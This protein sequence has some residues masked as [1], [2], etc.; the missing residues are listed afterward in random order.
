[1]KPEISPA[2]SFNTQTGHPSEAGAVHRWPTSET[3]EFSVPL[4]AP[5][6]GVKVWAVGVPIKSSRQSMLFVEV[7]LDCSEAVDG[8][9]TTGYKTTFVVEWSGWNTMYFTASSLV[10]IGAPAGLHQVKRLRLVAGTSTLE[11]TVLE[12]GVVTWTSDVPLMWDRSDWMHTGKGTLPSR[13]EGLDV[14]W[15]YANLRYLQKPGRRHQTAYT[16]KMDLDISGYQA[17]TVW[18]ATDIRA[19]FSLVL[20]IDGVAVRTI[21]R[22]RGLGGGDEMRALISGHRLT[23]LTIEL[24][25]AEDAV[26][27]EIE[28]QVASSLRWV[29][30]ERKGV[31]TAK[32]GQVHG[33]TTVLPPIRVE[34]LESNI[35]P[36]GIM[37]SREDFLKL[38]SAAQSPGPLKKMADEIIAEATAHLDYSPEQYAGRYLPVDLGNQGC[39]RKVSPSDQMYHL[40]SC[41]VYGAVAYALTGDLRHGQTARRSLF[42][43]LRCSTWQ[44]GFPSRIPCGLPG[45]RAPFIE[46]ATAECVAQCYDF[47]YPLLSDAER[48]EVED[49]LYEKALPWIDMYLRYYGEG[50]LLNSNQGAVYIAGLVNAA[51]V[52]RRSHPDVDVILERGIA[53]FPRMMN[54]YY[55]ETGA[56]NEGPGYWEYTTQYASAA[57]IAICRH[58]S[59]RVQDYAPK[60]LSRTMDYLMHLR[61]LSREK[62]SFLPLSDNIEG[63]GYDFM[64]GSFMFFAKYYQDPNALWLWHEYFASRANLPGSNFFGKKMAGAC[65]LS[66]LMNFLLYVEDRPT[67]PLLPPSKHFTGSDRIMLRTG[68]NYGDILFFFEGGAQTFDHT[69]CDKG[70]FIMEAYGERFAADPGVVKYQDPACN[71]Y[72]RTSYHNLV[73]LKGRD[74]DYLDPKNA[75]LLDQ[76]ELSKAFDYIAA[77]LRNSYKYLIHYRRRILFVRPSYFLILDQVKA[78]E[79]G[80]EWNYHSCAPISGI[81][82]EKGLIR[83]SGTKAG[84]TMALGCSHALKARVGSYESAGMVLTHNLV[85]SPIEPTTTLTVAALL[86]PFPL[87]RDAGLP[88]PVVQVETDS[89]SVIFTVTGAW[90]IDSVRCGLGIESSSPDPII[91]VCRVAGGKEMIFSSQN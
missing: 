60:H 49:A 53:W 32:V 55:K 10:K 85:L 40:N 59:W 29:L 39:E 63:V 25:Q 5:K 87:D 58:Q 91:E 64:N 77:D 42:T 24:E 68:C 79:S 35:L 26:V 23:A 17:V 48:R 22:R 61:S 37:I 16:R 71:N 18:T 73:T 6:A 56:S 51:L 76:V 88:E 2:T 43:A 41:M 54:N 67:Q 27:D 33:L 7:I 90:G 12:L 50:Y 3:P 46:T 69:H 75:V 36:V 47:I 84:M 74:Q 45:Y 1:M 8:P 89:D 14:E 65:S 28:V 11:G 13:E 82:L 66:G 57:L 4:G 19:N 30:L 21:D 78:N 38:R 34:K 20:E 44:C 62:L 72:K 70:E 31:D 81:D 86:L 80:L 52:A 15:M 9:V 83:F